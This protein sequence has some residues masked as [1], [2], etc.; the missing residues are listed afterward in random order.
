MNI[1]DNKVA[2]GMKS[3]VFAFEN[4]AIKYLLISDSLFRTIDLKKRRDYNSLVQKIQK[5]SQ[6]CIFS[7]LHTSGEQ[8]NALTGIAAILH[9]AL[10]TDF[11]EEEEE[12]I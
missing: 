12:E 9:F 6:V 8:L 10:E 7:S 11:V 2:Y 3:V 1:D 5:N 4:K